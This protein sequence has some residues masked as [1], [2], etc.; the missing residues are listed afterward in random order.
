MDR[1]ILY[2]GGEPSRYYERS[3]SV[4]GRYTVF[5]S[6]Q[7][8]DSGSA[9]LLARGISRL[10]IPCYVDSLDPSVDGNDPNLESYIRSV[11]RGCS[12]L[13]AVVSVSTSSSWWVPLEIGVALEGYKHIG[14]YEINDVD[15]PSYL[16]QWPVMTEL[17]QALRWANAIVRRSALNTHNEW[18]RSPRQS[19]YQRDTFFNSL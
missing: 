3:S 10:G 17:P 16:W 11:I 18:R 19:S 7:S 2:V 14:T 4:Q 12:A 15:L 1:G 8:R 6:H 9:T 13:L 5:I